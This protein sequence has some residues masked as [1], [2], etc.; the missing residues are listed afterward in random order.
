V[1]KTHTP[2]VYAWRVFG[3]TLAG[4]VAWI[5]VAFLFVIL[6]HP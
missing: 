5:V 4:V 6:R 1:A 3:Y 2:D